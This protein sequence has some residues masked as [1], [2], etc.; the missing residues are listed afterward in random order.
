[1]SWLGGGTVP[2][3]ALAALGTRHWPD[4]EFLDVALSA[5]RTEVR[6]G[7]VERLEVFVEERRPP[8]GG[9]AARVRAGQQARLARTVRADRPA[10]TPVEV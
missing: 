7:Y 9:A 4:G 6:Q 1:M 3:G 2:V 8:L 10:R 5:V